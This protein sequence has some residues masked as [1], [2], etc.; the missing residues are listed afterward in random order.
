MLRKVLYIG[1]VLHLG[2]VYDGIHQAIIS[3]EQFEQ[4]CQI[5]KEKNKAK[6]PP[7][8]NYLFPGLV[9]CQDCGST[10]SPCFTNK[11]KKGKRKRYYYYRCSCTQKRDW[12]ACTIKEVSATK[13]D[14]L[15]VK[16]FTNIATDPQYLESLSCKLKFSPSEQ[17]GSN[18]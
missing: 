13:L 11:L 4:A 16:S 6:W 5:H 18:G 15:I 3:P 2:K 10:M 9:T 12:T 17:T 1:K 14:G 8:K 7:A